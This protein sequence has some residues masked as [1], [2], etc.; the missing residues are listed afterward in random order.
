M[1]AV[2]AVKF[3]VTRLDVVTELSVRDG[4]DC[5]QLITVA[6]KPVPAVT[7]KGSVA[8]PVPVTV[9]RVLDEEK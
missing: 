5:T 1:L 6:Q 7:T 8:L 3:H 2:V 4:A 9:S